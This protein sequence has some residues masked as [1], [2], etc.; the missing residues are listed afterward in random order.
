MLPPLIQRPRRS[1]RHRE[2][3]VTMALVALSIVGIVA[4]AALSIDIGTLYQSSAEAQRAADAGALAAAR[5]ISMSGL[6]GDPT[7]TA[8]WGQ[9][10]GAAGTATPAA[11]AA[12]QQN[13]V[14]GKAI[15]IASITVTYSAGNG[16]VSAGVSDCTGAGSEFPINPVVTVYVQQ[17]NLP[18][19]FA[20]VFGIF[21]KNW[22]AVT[23]SA[24]ATA[25]AFNSSNAG[26]YGVQPRCVKPWMVPNYDPLN[27]SSSC[28][29]ATCLP[30]VNTGSNGAIE[31]GGIYPTGVIGESFWLVPDCAPGGPTCTLPGGTQPQANAGTG[32]TPNLQYVPGQVPPLS[33]ATAIPSSKV[34]ACSE[35]SGSAY[36]QAIAGC[37]QSTPY[38]CGG[39]GS[40]TVDL[41]E[42]PISTDDTSN[43][44][45]CLIHQGTD[46]ASDTLTTTLISGQDTLD[47]FATTPTLPATYPFQVQAGTNNP[48]TN[49]GLTSGTAITSSTSIV[50]VPIYNTGTTITPTGTTSV[51]IVGF[52]QVFVNYVDS[53]GNIYVT[54]MNVTGCGITPGTVLHGTSPVPVRLITPPTS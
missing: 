50:S 49:A 3:G 21:N 16:A 27:P 8:T 52:L 36:A 19:F 28:S 42:N 46:S 15:P 25:E 1:A 14:G 45:Q 11:I 9:T 18:T 4:M 32:P 38:E 35:I 26:S 31:H 39:P 44:A 33:T 29:G 23:A 13:A 47:P 41:N 51:N 2:R 17:T 40:N 24:S 7:N 10:C 12:V 53:T 48:L 20:H 30:F 22:N 34:G 54:V 43:G 37:D 5:L 6:T